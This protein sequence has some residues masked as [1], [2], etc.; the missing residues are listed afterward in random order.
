M[1]SGIDYYDVL[2]DE[3]FGSYLY[4]RTTSTSSTV[5]DLDNGQLYTFT[6]VAV[7]TDFN[8]AS[9]SPRSATPF[10]TTPAQATNVS[11]AAG[12]GE[13]TISWTAPDDGGSPIIDTRVQVFKNGAWVHG[14]TA[15]PPSASGTVKG[16]DGGTEYSFRLRS[17]NANG[18]GPWSSVVTATPT[19]Q[20]AGLRRPSS[21][22]SRHRQALAR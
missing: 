15:L 22:T 5:T 2:I 18:W 12:P 14:A 19:A 1:G 8:S 10:S 16:L 20:P 17:Q 4:D 9:S 21:G 7:D 13:A 11:A 6:I 3:G